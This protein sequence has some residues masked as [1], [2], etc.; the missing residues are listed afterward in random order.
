MVGRVF[1][2]KDSGCPPKA[3]RVIVGEGQT[4]PPIG[5]ESNCRRDL[6]G[7]PLSGTTPDVPMTAVGE[8]V[9]VG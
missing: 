5:W 6:T 9:W 7:A 4:V 3:G 1:R 8:N 2:I